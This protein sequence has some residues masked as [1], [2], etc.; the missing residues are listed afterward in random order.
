MTN[1]AAYSVRQLAAAW[2]VSP[3]HVLALIRCGA[4]LAADMRLPG[5]SRPRYRIAADDADEYFARRQ[6]A[7]APA[8]RV[9]RRRRLTTIPEHID[10]MW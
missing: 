8:P 9:R 7:A 10:A 4:L 6:A 2:G 3:G 1:R 5:A